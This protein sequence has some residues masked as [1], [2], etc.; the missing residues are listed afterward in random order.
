MLTFLTFEETFQRQRLKLTKTKTRSALCSS[1]YEKHQFQGQ[2]KIPRFVNP[3]EWPE[4]LR[5]YMHCGRKTNVYQILI[6]LA[7]AFMIT[8]GGLL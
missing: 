7:T 1:L 6:R 5:E 8:F 2:C 3:K 4:Q